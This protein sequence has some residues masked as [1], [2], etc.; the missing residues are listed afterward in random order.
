MLP[1]QLACQ[2]ANVEQNFGGQ[3]VLATF[4]PSLTRKLSRDESYYATLKGFNIVAQGQ[5]M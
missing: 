1:S 5:A 4:A 3:K 2:V